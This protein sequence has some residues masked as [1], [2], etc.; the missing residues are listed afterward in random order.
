MFGVVKIGTALFSQ[1]DKVEDLKKFNSSFKGNLAFVSGAGTQ[2]KAIVDGYRS[3]NFS[4][5]FLDQLGIELTH[6]NARALARI[7]GGVYCRD[8]S[9]IDA[10]KL[11]KPVTGGQIP[12]QSTDAV[13]A[14]LAD[15]LGADVLILVKDVGGLYNQDPKEDKGARV[16]H[17]LGFDELLSYVKD[18]TRAGHY[19]VIDN[20]AIQ[21]IRR[22]KIKTHV[23]GP[24]FDFSSG[25]L[26]N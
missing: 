6:V 23:V 19:G 25:T 26:I 15:F 2:A 16:I 20:Q 12:G 21:V 24:E 8:F 3:F 4:E 5:G 22:S 13:A 9:Q 14:E 7:I 11:R 17:T 18:D 10:N 1:P